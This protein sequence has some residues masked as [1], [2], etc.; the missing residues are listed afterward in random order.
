MEGTQRNSHFGLQVSV[1]NSLS[2]PYAPTLQAGS[3]VFKNYLFIF[4]LHAGKEIMRGRW[5]VVRVAKK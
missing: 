4:F 2:A 5:S 3:G 1:P